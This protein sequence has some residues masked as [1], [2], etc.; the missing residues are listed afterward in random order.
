MNPDKLRLLEKEGKVQW[1]FQME[2]GE[3]KSIPY[4]YERYVP[5]N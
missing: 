1:K 3:R 5:S 4:K 2:P